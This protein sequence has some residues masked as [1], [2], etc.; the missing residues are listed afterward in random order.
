MQPKLSAAAIAFTLVG[1]LATSVAAQTQTSANQRHQE[2]PVAQLQIKLREIPPEMTRRVAAIHAALQPSAKAWVE[3]QAR[4]EAQKPAPDVPSIEAAAYNRFPT[5]NSRGSAA[6]VND[7]NALVAIVMMQTAND[8]ETDLQKMMAQMQAITNAKQ[9]M[10]NL[11]LQLQPEQAAMKSAKP[12][13]TCQTATCRSLPSRLKELSA[14]TATIPHPVETTV[15]AN[16][17][18]A[19]LNALTNQLQSNLDLMNDLSQ[20]DQLKLQSLMDQRSKI[21]EAVS[22]LM[23]KMDDTASSVI[24]N[25]K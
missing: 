10:R 15:A 23:K 6:T 21:I 18:Y 17:T 11:I 22:N 9:Q 16:P 19:N 4:I 5:L 8:A 25:I 14:A 2:E 7:I 20:M 1:C 13:S 24:Q 12:S 3:Q